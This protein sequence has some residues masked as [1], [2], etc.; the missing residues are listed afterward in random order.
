MH[1]RVVPMFLLQMGTVLPRKIRHSDKVECYHYRDYHGG[2]VNA[3]CYVR[4]TCCCPI[5]DWKQ[6]NCQTGTLSTSSGRWSN[7]YKFPLTPACGGRQQSG[8]QPV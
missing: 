8:Y 6:A 4:G 3:L 7:A 5:K 2:V 1:G